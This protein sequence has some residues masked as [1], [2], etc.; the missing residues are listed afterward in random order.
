MMVFCSLVE[1][2]AVGYLN[3]RVKLMA[4]QRKESR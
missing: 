2:A 3:K 1:Y 4:A